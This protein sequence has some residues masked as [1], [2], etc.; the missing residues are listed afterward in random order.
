VSAPFVKWAGGKRALLPTLTSL[1]PASYGDYYEPFVGGG[2]L[3]FALQPSRAFLN[4]ANE[5][6]VN[7]YAVVRDRVDDLLTALTSHRNT[8]AHFLRVRAQRPEDLDEVARAARLIYLNRTCF[9]GLYRV[10]RRGEF[11]TPYAG[12]RNPTLVPETSL[13]AASAA[14]QGV[15]LTAGS[16]LDGCSSAGRGDFVYLDP[17]YVPVGAFSDFR[18]Y[19]REQFRE[20]DHEEL[21]RL[22]KDLDARGCHV[23]LS[24]SYT[25]W[26]LDLYADWTIHEVTTRRAINSDGAGR[27]PVREVI[28]AND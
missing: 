25:P 2:A 20:E 8:E 1:A 21:A 9:N 16:Y 6:L 10:N 27:G 28:V 3:F 23:R 17:P 24:N 14:L 5:E 12:Y 19:H 4:D 15:A 13:R 26:V 18:R 7:C 22:F 11:N